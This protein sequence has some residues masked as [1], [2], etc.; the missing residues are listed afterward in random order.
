MALACMYIHNTAHDILSTVYV[1]A[2]YVVD[3]GI[4]RL[5]NY[6]HMSRSGHSCFV[7]ELVAGS[8]NHSDAQVD[9]PTDL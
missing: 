7:L 4:G 9:Q 6:C 3:I 8:D 2:T 1:M 5:S